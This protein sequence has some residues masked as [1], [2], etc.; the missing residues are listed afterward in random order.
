MAYDMEKIYV[1]VSM[2]CEPIRS[3]ENISLATSDP[4]SYKDSA[5][6]IRAFA[7]KS[8]EYQ[9]PVSFFIH[10]EVAVAHPE[11]FW[12]QEKNGATLGLH[13][14]PYKIKD[15]RF[16]SHFGALLEN[17]QRTILAE[18]SAVWHSAIGRR[19][20]YFRPG[21]FSANDSTFRVLEDL[22]F[23]GGSISCPGRLYPDLYAVWTGAPLDPHRANASF[24]LMKGNLNFINVPLTVD[25]SQPK[26]SGAHSFYRDL[27][28]DY[29]ESDYFQ[30]A[31]NIV[32]RLK[33]QKPIV[34]VLM[35]VTHNDND[36]TDPNDRVSQNYD[37]VLE[38]ITKACAKADVEPVGVNLEFVCDLVH[39]QTDSNSPR[40]VIGHDS[41][42]AG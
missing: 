36:F 42:Q 35:V 31:R 32:E 3:P 13:I 14:H 16:V 27:R 10:P 24:R 18:A 12:E 19:P 37:I 38:A 9:F 29:L 17:Q 20:L 28:P 11:V 8:A 6:F 21:T 25:I 7:A 5:R 33:S 4:V 15:T 40:F 34:P 23:L 26:Q 22:G 39:Q 2:D 41:L 30:T 1:V